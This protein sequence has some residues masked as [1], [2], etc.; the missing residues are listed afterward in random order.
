MLEKTQMM[1]TMEMME[2]KMDIWGRQT[3]FENNAARWGWGRTERSRL[4]SKK[5]VAARSLVARKM[6]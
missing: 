5:L 4:S 6:A 3:S 2:L 1:E